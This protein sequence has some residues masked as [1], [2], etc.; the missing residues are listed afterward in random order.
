MYPQGIYFD[1]CIYH[2]PPPIRNMVV[3]RK[4]FPTQDDIRTAIKY[5]VMQSSNADAYNID[6]EISRNTF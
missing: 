2:S 3:A 6:N 4:E 5:L 1:I